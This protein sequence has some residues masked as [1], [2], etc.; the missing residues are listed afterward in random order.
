MNRRRGYT[1]IELS[2][3][4][5]VLSLI[6]VLIS[7]NLGR[8]I[9]AT[10]KRS[11]YAGFTRMFADARMRAAQTGGPISMSVSEGGGF[12][13]SSANADGE[14][15]VLSSLPSVEGVEATGLYLKDGTDAGT[16][17]EV[18]FY[19]D[20]TCDGGAVDL[21]ENNTEVRYQIQPATSLV[22]IVST[23]TEFQED[24]WQAGEFSNGG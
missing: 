8:S 14:A 23:D 1:L 15:N 17:W 5:V 11:F 2:A 9:R 22:A 4:I 24:R 19:P 16:D 13:L 10:Q 12:Q 21:A 7:P 3:V 18:R 6:A 20:G